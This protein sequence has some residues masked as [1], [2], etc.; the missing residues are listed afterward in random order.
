MEELERQLRDHLVAL[1]WAALVVV[2]FPSVFG[3]R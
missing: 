1:T 2:M 3:Y